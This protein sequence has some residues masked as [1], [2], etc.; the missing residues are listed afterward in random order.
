VA[1]LPL[2]HRAS[3]TTS[4]GSTRPLWTDPAQL[5]KD[6]NATLT[7]C[8]ATPVRAQWVE[9][10]QPWESEPAVIAL[11]RP[12]L[13]RAHNRRTR[14]TEVGRARS[15]PAAARANAAATRTLSAD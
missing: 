15:H 4:T 1:E 8:Q 5:P 2:G 9:V 7:A 11:M 12:P 6:A 14:L 13:N 10:P 3:Y